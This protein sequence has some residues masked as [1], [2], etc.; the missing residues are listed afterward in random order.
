MSI[1]TVNP[2]LASAA[3][4]IRMS[5]DAQEQSP[6]QQR[7]QIE[8]LA[9]K[10]GCGRLNWYCDAA[11]S[12]ND[13]KHRLGFQQ[14]MTDALLGKFRVILCWSLDRFGRFDSLE[15][16]SWIA[17]L[18]TAGVMLVTVAEGKMNWDDAGGRLIYMIQQE[19]KHAFLLDR[20]RDITRG[21]QRRA[22]RPGL[23]LGPPPYGYDTLLY[24]ER[25]I[26]VRRVVRG[27]T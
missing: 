8:K 16:A 2:R 20:A 18:R 25:G 4:Y 26:L 19:Q 3:G 12:G 24:D 9:E 23:H 11:I 27:E 7:E 17:P 1:G 14:M 5:A 10:M 6:S 15:A 21:F 22:K 13:T